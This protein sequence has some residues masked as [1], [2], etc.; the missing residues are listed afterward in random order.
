MDYYIVGQSVG[1]TENQW[2]GLK[3]HLPTS[4][5]SHNDTIIN[6]E[7]IRGQSGNVPGP[8]LDGLTQSSTET[9]IT[10]TRNL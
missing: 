5:V 1:W 2:N 3:S 6:R 10:A 7:G 8:Y 9:E 4:S